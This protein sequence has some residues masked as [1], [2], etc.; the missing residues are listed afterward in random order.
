VIQPAI[1]ADQDDHVLDRA[2]GPEL[3][4]GILRCLLFLRRVGHRLCDTGGDN[5]TETHSDVAS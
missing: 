5:V 4:G 2:L 1:L 3:G